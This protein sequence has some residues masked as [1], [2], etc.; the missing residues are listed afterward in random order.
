VVRPPKNGLWAYIRDGSVLSL[1]TAP[2]IYSLILPFAALD[3]WTTLYQRVC[4]PAYGMACV[5]RR[6]YFALDRHKLEYLNAIEKMNCTFCT[7]ANGVIA[8][9]REVAARTEQFWCPIKHGRA[10][11]APHP[12]YSV[13][14]GYG[15]GPAYTQRLPLLRA[16][17]QAPAGGPW[18]ARRQGSLGAVARRDNR[19]LFVRT[20]GRS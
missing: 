17:L 14:V 7:Y 19:D 3:V 5:P 9:V 16:A 4:F 18:V 1:V 11:A 10:I 12:L 6:P 13:F 20:R 2:I 15:D 8:Y